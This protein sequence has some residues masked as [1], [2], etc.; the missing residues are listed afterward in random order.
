MYVNTVWAPMCFF[1]LLIRTRLQ[2]SAYTHKPSPTLSHRQ[3]LTLTN[4]NVLTD[5]LI[6]Y[7][8]ALCGGVIV[9]NW[10]HMRCVC[11]CVCMSIGGRLWHLRI[12][13]VT[14]VSRDTELS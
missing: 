11:V 9:A 1:T 13:N 10:I 2:C 7:G 4:T 12:I 6:R 5:H 14:Y 8:T 3:T